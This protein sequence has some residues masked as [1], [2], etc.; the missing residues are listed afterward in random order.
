M[1]A[2]VAPTATGVIFDLDGTLADAVEDVHTAL[3]TALSRF[4]FVPIS[5][6]QTRALVGHGLKDLVR[7]A[8][9]CSDGAMLTEIVVAYREHYAAHML[10]HT[11]LFPGIENMLDT[12][13]EKGVSISVLSNKS[14]EFTAAICRALLKPWP[15]VRAQGFVESRPRKPDPGLALELAGAM[16]I[17]PPS[18]FFVGD[19]EV[20]METGRSAK[21]HTVGVTWGYRS[22]EHVLAAKPD[23]VI[24]RP[25]ELIDVVNGLRHAHK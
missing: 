7:R 17:S 5:L 2:H 1:R 21:M 8:S 19:S 16:E 15:I 4:R 13:V 24:D 11:A 22:R 3:N 6:S 18:I 25:S 10:D 20:D 9:G 14:H 12:L 23:Y